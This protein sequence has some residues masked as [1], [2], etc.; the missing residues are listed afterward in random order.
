MIANNLQK[1]YQ[2][3]KIAA[4]KSGRLP[5][6]I[7]LVAVSKRK[8]AQEIK[9]A[10][11]CNQTVF[12]E[13]YIQEAIE[14]IS[15]LPHSIN[16]HF[17]GPLQSNKTRL[18]VKYFDVIE[19]VDRIKIAR[20]LNKSADDAKKDIDILVQV[21]LSKE[22]QKAGIME[23]DAEQFFRELL[24]FPRVKTRGLMTMPPYA[25]NPEQNRPFFNKLKQ[26]SEM[27]EQKNLFTTDKPVILSMGMSND[28]KIA[29]EEGSTL[30]RIGTAIFGQRI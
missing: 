21:N 16:W 2:Q 1:I 9:E 19:T 29:I 5:Q 25:K 7:Q 3:I 17:I 11:D 27:L 13:N 28:Y 18:A 4:E 23:E 6:D 14:K 8:S 10:F 26:L 30:V 15:V 20:L 12:G 24:N 22:Q